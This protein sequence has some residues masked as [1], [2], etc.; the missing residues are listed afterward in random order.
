MDATSEK[1]DVIPNQRSA[2]FALRMCGDVMDLGFNCRDIAANSSDNPDK[3][4]ILGRGSSH[5][6]SLYTVNR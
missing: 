2:G 3:L 5:D 4:R 1:A 6:G